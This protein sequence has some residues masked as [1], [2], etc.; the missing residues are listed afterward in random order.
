MNPEDNNSNSQIYVKDALKGPKIL[1]CCFYDYTI[2]PGEKET[3]YAK[4]IL[5][6]I[7]A[8]GTCLTK[9]VEYF[10]IEVDLVK[11]YEDAIGKLTNKNKDGKCEYYAVWFMSSNYLQLPLPENGSQ[12]YRDQFID[13]VIKFWKNGGSVIA[14]CD[15]DPFTFLVNL[16]LDRIEFPET[17]KTNLRVPGFHQGR[18]HLKTDP[19]GKLDQPGTFNSSPI[20]FEKG[21]RAPLSHNFVDIYEGV[22]ISYAPD[23]Q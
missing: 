14:L 1:F 2:N 8:G 19:T 20:E 16:F 17:G 9:A 11:H 3:V 18:T 4:Y 6:P 13:C 15:N 23:D 22:T 21:W 10:G 5:E 7:T 12:Y